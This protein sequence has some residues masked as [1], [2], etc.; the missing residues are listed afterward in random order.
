MFGYNKKTFI[1][2]WFVVLV[3]LLIGAGSAFGYNSLDGSFDLFAGLGVIGEMFGG[4]A[5]LGAIAGVLVAA[6]I[7]VGGLIYMGKMDYTGKPGL[8]AFHVVL[9][10]AVVAAAVFIGGSWIVVPADGW[11][12]LGLG[13]G[14]LI[15]VTAATAI[16]THR[17][18]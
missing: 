2:N 18:K 13:L 9:G 11:I 7:I 14:T 16:V 12:A 4:I 5:S 15:L 8:F 1:I 3:V 6:A 10:F 17:T